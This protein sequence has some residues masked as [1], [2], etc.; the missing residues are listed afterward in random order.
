MPITTPTNT[1][2]KIL[3]SFDNETNWL[4]HDGTGWHKYTGDLTSD[5]INSNS[6]TD[7]QT[8]F[9]NKSVTQLTNDLSGLGII[10]ISLGFMWQ[11]KTTN[12]TITPTVSPVTLTYQSLPHIEYA[13]Y[14]RY[15][16][17]LTFGVKIIRDPNDSTKTNQ[18]A[19]K[20]LTNR[21]RIL[22]PNLIVTT[23]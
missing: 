12:V 9:V 18:M 13:S 7:L 6:N 22:N 21:T 23:N 15:D 14:G 11:L 5:F 2:I 16:E 4:Y 10:P 3:T 20:N 1:S 17:N 19:V 8:Y